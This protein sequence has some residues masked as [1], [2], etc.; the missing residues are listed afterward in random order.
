LDTDANSLKWGDP[1]PKFQVHVGSVLVVAASGKKLDVRWAYAIS[2][3]CEY[4]IANGAFAMLLENVD[5]VIFT[6]ARRDVNRKC[7]TKEA[8]RA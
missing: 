7:V 2:R 3:Y 6:K 4:Q 1:D 8:S 5:E